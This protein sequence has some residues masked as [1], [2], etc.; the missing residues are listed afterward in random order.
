M[1]Y[2]L[3]YSVYNIDLWLY[4][5]VQG[6]KHYGFQPNQIPNSIYYSIPGKDD[7]SILLNYDFTKYPFGVWLESNERLK[8]Q[9]YALL[10]AEVKK[11]ETEYDELLQRIRGDAM[12]FVSEYRNV[13]SGD[14]FGRCMVE[15]TDVYYEKTPI[16]VRDEYAKMLGIWTHIFLYSASNL[17]QRRPD[18][19]KLFF[20]MWMF[21]RPR[22]KSIVLDYTRR[23]EAIE[24]KSST[25]HDPAYL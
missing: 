7:I 18:F 11:Y 3:K 2:P 10:D 25:H 14:D 1:P 24:S 12:H 17:E 8:P 9:A 5:M 23:S 6:M 22:V 19:A 20:Q 21:I 15:F 16:T 13:E 4:A